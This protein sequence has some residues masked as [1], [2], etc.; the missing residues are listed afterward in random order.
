MENLPPMTRQPEYIGD[1]R[2][3]RELGRGATGVVYLCEHA[4]LGRQLA[5]KVLAAQVSDEPDFLARFQRE[6]ETAAKLRHPNIVQVYDQA[7]RDGVFFIAMEY[8][9]SRTLKSLISESGPVSVPE[10]CRLIGQLLNALEHAH[11]LGVVHRDVKPANVMLTDAGDIALTDF[12]IAHNSAKEKLTGTGIALGTPEYMAPEQFDGKAEARSDLYA[13]AIVLYEMLT[14]F[15]PFRADSVTEVLKKQILVEP[16][17]LSEVDFTIPAPLSRVVSK[18][19]SK[20]PG[21]RYANAAEMRQALQ[22]ALCEPAPVEPKTRPSQAPLTQSLPTTSSVGPPRAALAAALMLTVLGLLALAQRKPP[23]KPTQT[24]RAIAT[25]QVAVVTTVPTPKSSPTPQS[26]LTPTPTPTATEVVVEQETPVGALPTQAEIH[27]GQGLGEVTLGDSME[28]VE[29]EWGPPYEGNGYET[30][31]IWGY[32]RD[33]EVVLTFDKQTNKLTRID[34]N[35]NAYPLKQ[36]AKLAVGVDQE[37]V[38]KQFP[39][40]T[41]KDS[42]TLDYNNLGIYF[43]FNTRS[44]RKPSKYGEHMCQMITIYEP[45]HTPIHPS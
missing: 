1:Y 4:N 6:G 9:G 24:P 22:A 8:L 36:D 30:E 43:E 27:P 39:E 17:P 12:S 35:T 38:L 10:A 31:I 23:V 25:Q 45:E 42:A 16:A 3:I 41:I 2:V 40:P 34:I 33:Q 5:V 15:T 26:S 18:A 21:Q 28:Q 20:D 7:C 13:A 44:S 29:S 32:G 14:G 19:L 11:A 37:S